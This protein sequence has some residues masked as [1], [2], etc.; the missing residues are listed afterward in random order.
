MKGENKVNEYFEQEIMLLKKEVLNVCNNNKEIID[1]ICSLNDV[2]KKT[3]LYTVQ[4]DNMIDNIQYEIFDPRFQAGKLFFPTIIGVEET[5]EKIINERKSMARFGDGEFSIMENLCRQKFQKLDKRLA[6]RLT[7]VIRTEDERILIGIANNYGNLS[8]YTKYARDSIRIYMTEE[9][10][11]GHEKYLQKDR[12]Y[13]DAYMTRPYVMHRD[14]MTDAPKQRFNHL[15]KIW[16]DRKVIVVEGSQTRMGV[17]N[18]L[19]DDAYELKRILAPA[20]SSFD[21]YDEILRASLKHAEKDILFL[22]S[23]GPSAG[24]LAYD[25]AMEGYQALDIGHLDLE[26][27]WF[28]AGKG[29]RVP[30][31]YK[32][33]NEIDGGDIV[34]DINDPIYESQILERF[35][36]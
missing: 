13:Y 5:V 17:G 19:L 18:D 14:N 29:E 8:K 30:V 7:E 31:P 28:L 16:K 34:E 11:S 33:N 35:D 23:M 27:E 15:K 20:T 21:K 36:R 24:I 2:V 10:R 1:I 3:E 25:L 26:Y 4:L 32:Y 12:I 22:I 6:E 9:I